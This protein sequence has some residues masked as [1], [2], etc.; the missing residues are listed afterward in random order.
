MRIRG[1][2]MGKI[3]SLY[4]KLNKLKN[5]V[6]SYKLLSFF[7]IA[8]VTLNL[9]LLL[10]F[11][12]INPNINLMAQIFNYFSSKA[13][14]NITIS[15]GLP[16]IILLIDYVFKI[17][18]KRIE[19]RKN[20]QLDTIAHTNSLWNDLAEITTELIYLNDLKNEEKIV[21][22]NSNI[23]KFIINAEGI[24]NSWNSEFSNLKF[25]LED[26]ILFSDVFLSPINVL[27]SAII[28]LIDFKEINSYNKDQIRLIQHNIQVIYLGIKGSLHHPILNI[29]KNF[30]EYDQINDKES[31]K[32]IK[33]EIQ[34]EFI[35]LKKFNFI[36]IKEIFDYFPS[37]T[38]NVDF[39]NIN[40][41]LNAMKVNDE[42]EYESFKEKMEELY[43]NL[44]DEQKNELK[45]I[46][47]FNS[48]LIQKLANRMN[49][50]EFNA[51]FNHT[52]EQYIKLKENSNKNKKLIE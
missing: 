17:N 12:R 19:E 3:E 34:K 6:L 5:I 1:D 45:D 23:D 13:F 41:Y 42:Y 21:E 31:K 18:E 50:H 7:L 36:L 14:Q 48:D 2:E 32:S 4:T 43:F 16:I 26:E 29:L 28:S 44:S 52:R 25:I 10:F 49:I 15:L 20:R 38:S 35:K 46:Y 37:D 8:L 11:I 27:L 22:I 51:N 24:V 47:Q 33:K 9:L 39:K 30:V 40:Q